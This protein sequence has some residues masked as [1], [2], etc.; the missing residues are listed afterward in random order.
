MRLLLLAHLQDVHSKD[1][2]P[3]ALFRKTPKKQASYAKLFDDQIVS[4]IDLYMVSY[5]GLW[6]LLWT[7]N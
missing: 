4:M 6:A 7:F 3:R 5:L 2:H 1:A